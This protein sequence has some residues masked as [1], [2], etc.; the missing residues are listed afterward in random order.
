ML[1]SII[2]TNFFTDF[3]SNAAPEHF[4]TNRHFC[5]IHS[6]MHEIRIIVIQYATLEFQQNTNF[7]I[8][9]Y[10]VLIY[11]TSSMKRV[12]FISVLYLAFWLGYLHYIWSVVFKFIYSEKCL[13][14]IN[15]CNLFLTHFLLCKWTLV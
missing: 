7:I 2:I 14:A 13:Q 4:F 15:W 1:A 8:T 6:C 10:K 9:R 11:I 5:C 12:A 3:L